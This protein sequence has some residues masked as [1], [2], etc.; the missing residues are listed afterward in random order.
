VR[1]W[2]EEQ[3]WDKTPPGPSIPAEIV[4]RA[5]ARYQ[6]VFNRLTSIP[7]KGS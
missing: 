4:S 3:D 6:E 2:L 5:Q 1:N 7:Q